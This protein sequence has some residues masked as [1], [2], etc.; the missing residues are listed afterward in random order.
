[1]R[2]PGV[3]LAAVLAGTGL[4]IALNEPDGRSTAMTALFASGI[5]L[6]IGLVIGLRLQYMAEA[7]GDG[8]GWP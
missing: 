7:S 4:W 1:M 2:Q 3:G 6:A 8:C 5:V